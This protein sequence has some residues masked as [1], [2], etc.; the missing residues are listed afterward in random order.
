MHH[1][2]PSFAVLCSK[3]SPFSPGGILQAGSARASAY[4]TSPL[5][6]PAMLAAFFY[7]RDGQGAV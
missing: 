2:I 6:W 7:R 1:H 5:K 3:K 4:F